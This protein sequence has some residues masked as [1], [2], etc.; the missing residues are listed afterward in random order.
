MKKQKHMNKLNKKIKIP[1]WSIVL[2]LGILIIGMAAIMSSVS[3][4]EK[5]TAVRAYEQKQHFEQASLHD[6]QEE[7]LKKMWY[8]LGD[9]LGI[10]TIILAIGLA[11]GLSQGIAF[12]RVTK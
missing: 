4:V 2:T 1:V 12:V 11:F 8:T 5:E 6:I 3:N 10:I 9:S 7:A